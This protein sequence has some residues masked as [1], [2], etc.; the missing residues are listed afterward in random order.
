MDT[1]M[2]EF[3]APIQTNRTNV[4][5]VQR[6]KGSLAAQFRTTAIGYDRFMVIRNSAL[7]RTFFN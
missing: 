1:S 6:Q 2:E 5:A 7:V 4:R 3:L